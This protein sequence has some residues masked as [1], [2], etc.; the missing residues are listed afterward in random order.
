VFVTVPD[1][2]T[3]LFGLATCG[4]TDPMTTDTGGCD[5]TAGWDDAEAVVSAA[6]TAGADA[7]TQALATARKAATMARVTVTRTRAPGAAC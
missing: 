1:T 3:V 5:E 4:L 2:V 7:S 6:R